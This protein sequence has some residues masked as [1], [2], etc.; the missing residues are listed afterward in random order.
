MIYL[1]W[2]YGLDKAWTQIASLACGLLTLVLA[3]W[4]RHYSVDYTDGEPFTLL[5]W[6]RL[7]RFPLFW[8]GLVF[9]ALQ[10]V[11]MFNPSWFRESN[12]Y[13][14]GLLP[15][16]NIEWLPTNIDLAPLTGRAWPVIAVY[17]S[18]WFLVCALW[19]GITRRRSLQVLCWVLM[20]NAL[21]LG[22]V[23][24]IHRFSDLSHADLVLWTRKIKNGMPYGSF[25]SRN[26]ASAYFCLMLGMAAGLA[27]W[28]Y[29]EGRRRMAH[30]TPA[31][32]WVFAA[33]LLA[34]VVAFSYSRA[35]V[36]VAASFI[37]A[38]IL[39]QLPLHH[40]HSGSGAHLGV[41]VALL[42]V[43][44]LSAGLVIKWM[45][46]SQLEKRFSQL[47]EY[48]EAEG[49][50]KMRVE[51]RAHAIEMLSDHWLRGTGAGSFE[52]HFTRY[53]RND[54]YLTRSG[55]AR[56]E[57]AH[58]DWLEISIEQG[59]AGVLLIAA[60]YFWWLWRWIKAGGWKHPFALM[61]FLGSLQTLLHA[62]IDMPFQHPA[63]LATWWALLIMALRWAEFE[64]PKTAS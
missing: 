39:I 50:Y 59:I 11:G 44:L 13:F 25:V 53:V 21:A 60:A 49:S 19:V 28:H 22:V 29:F 8:C 2:S 45:D 61:I 62:T 56:W 12:G 37:L 24:L 15:L 51:A 16:P 63:V 42:G 26:H 3:L 4:P 18:T 54:P 10:V 14:W 48:G 36:I 52:H 38:A 46:F 33:A 34:L 40:M 27:A 23:A 17:A 57:H 20:A 43:F 7:I 31:G 35:G 1:P 30:S 32:V 58:N 9:V 64:A 55:R 47:M 5:P 6:R 41:K